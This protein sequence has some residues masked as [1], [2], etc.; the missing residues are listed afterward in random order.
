[1]WMWA[2]HTDKTC[3][4]TLSRKNPG[5]VLCAVRKAGLTDRKREGMGEAEQQQV[6]PE[7]EDLPRAFLGPRVHQE[8]GTPFSPVY[9]RRAHSLSIIP[10]KRMCRN[11]ED[12]DKFPSLR[13]LFLE[14]PWDIILATQSKRKL[15]HLLP[16]SLGPVWIP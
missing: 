4:L 14:I 2:R 9:T 10:S 7:V 6:F 1:M 3:V 5:S 12:M 15:H 16:L 13:E 8:H 11:R